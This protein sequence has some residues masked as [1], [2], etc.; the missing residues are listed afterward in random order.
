[1]KSRKIDQQK[2]DDFRKQHLHLNATETM[3]SDMALFLQ[4]PVHV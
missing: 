2:L 4:K 1:M 3:L